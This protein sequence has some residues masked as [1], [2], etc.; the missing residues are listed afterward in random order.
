[1]VEPANEIGGDAFDYALSADAVRLAIFDG[2]GHALGAG[3]IAAAAVSAYRAARRSGRGLVGQALAVD[4]ALA[5]HFPEAFATGVLCELDLH[6]GRLRYLA[7]GH[8]APLLLRGAKVVGALEGGRRTP[9][10]IDGSLEPSGMAVGEA[11]L[12]PG[13]SLVLHTDGLTEAR[14]ATGGFFGQQRL[15]DFLEREA[16]GAQPPPE[17]ARR[18]IRAVLRHQGGNLDDDA[19]VLLAQWFPSPAGPA[20][21]SG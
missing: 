18:L 20:I 21:G 13:D 7:A 15:V 10:G 19:T 1:M 4:D 9:F 5:T 8:P 11:V 17:T 14:S 2:M 12:Q 6:S 3:L 16:A